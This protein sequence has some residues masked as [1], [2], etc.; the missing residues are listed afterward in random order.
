MENKFTIRCTRCNEAFPDEVALIHHEVQKHN[1]EYECLVCEK[2]F[3]DKKKALRHI[4]T[5]EKGKKKRAKR[6]TFCWIC[7]YEA[8]CPLRLTKHLKNHYRHTKPKWRKVAKIQ[9]CTGCPYTTTKK[10]NMSRHKRKN[11]PERP[12]SIQPGQITFDKLWGLVSDCMISN[13]QVGKIFQTMKK[14]IGRRQ[15]EKGSIRKV[16]SEFLNSMRNFFNC[17]PTVFKNG[18]ETVHSTLTYCKDI[19]QFIEMIIKGRQLQDPKLI[20]GCDGG[21]NCNR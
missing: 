4:K 7:D 10:S 12:I 9:R 16:I 21:L 17:D 3:T 6:N 14:I 13:N 19:N 8:P 18:K 1:D 5:H 20:V 2:A 11:C 15:F